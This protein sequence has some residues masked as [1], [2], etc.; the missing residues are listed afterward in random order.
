[1]PALKDFALSIL[2]ITITWP[3]SNSFAAVHVL[4]GHTNGV[5]E[6][7]FSPDGKMLASASCDGSI[8]LW[9]VATGKQRARYESCHGFRCIA[10]S[11]DGKIL[12]AGDSASNIRI[13]NLANGKQARFFRGGPGQ[14]IGRLA[15]SPDGRLLA[16]TM[17]NHG[18]AKLWQVRSKK[19]LPGF[20][21]DQ[22]VTSVAFFPDGRRL[23]TASQEGTIC[24][25]QLEPRKKIAQFKTDCVHAYL[26][27]NGKKIAHS[28]LAKGKLSLQESATA[29]GA[30]EILAHGGHI[31]AVAFSPDSNVLATAS[32]GG[33]IIFWDV[34]NHQCLGICKGH[35]W[36]IWT[37]AF[38]PNGKLLA[39][40]SLDGTVR[41]WSTPGRK[42]TKSR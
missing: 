36:P 25:W 40:G 19:S 14:P 31:G 27:P 12:A 30:V 33:T 37:I 22:V 13:Y 35:V 10:F 23:A 9:E 21:G 28:G 39:S 20:P 2:A 32:T 7:A 26:S 3:V 18:E 6:V 16:A 42:Q 11:A 17:E 24:C 1:M 34:A 29:N 5:P 15:F 38:S 41:V 8:I 4:N